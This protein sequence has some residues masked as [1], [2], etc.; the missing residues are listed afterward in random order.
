MKDFNTV[1]LNDPNVK[2]FSIGAEKH[3]L[4]CSDLLKDSCKFIR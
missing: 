2:Y 3:P 1:V 4:F